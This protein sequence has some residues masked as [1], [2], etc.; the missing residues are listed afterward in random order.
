MKNIILSV[1]V[2]PLFSYAQTAT[3]HDI[4]AD[5]E[6]STTISIT[7][8]EKKTNS[9]E[10]QIT[11]GTATVSG[12]PELLQKSARAS[13]K[14]ACAEWKKELKEL[15]SANQV[16]V[17]NCNQPTCN[18]TGNSETVCSSQADYKLKIKVK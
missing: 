4:P 1:I 17:M 8:G 6:G 16:L 10:F 11:E 7:K 3:L 18:Q 15:N 12:E 9:E 14:T 5:Q 13:W 2:L